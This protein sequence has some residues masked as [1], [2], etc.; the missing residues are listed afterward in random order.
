MLDIEAINRSITYS[1][2]HLIAIVLLLFLIW[3][4]YQRYKK[5]AK[6]GTSD[7]GEKKG[8]LVKLLLQMEVACLISFILLHVSSDL[9]LVIRINL[10]S[11]PAYFNSYV[12]GF[13]SYLNMLFFIIMIIFIYLFALFANQL[14]FFKGK[15]FIMI[16]KLM[17]C[18]LGA[19]I[20]IGMFTGFSW[21]AEVD[22]NSGKYNPA[23]WIEASMG[24][25]LVIIIIPAIIS[26]LKAQKKATVEIERYGIIFI[27][28]FYL[29]I[30]ILL[31]F[32]GIFS[33]TGLYFFSYFS[34]ILMPF[35]I[36]FAYL[37]LIMPEGLRRWLLKRWLKQ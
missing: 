10:H 26:G 1:T 12:S 23:T 16:N 14:F 18:A 20:C 15:W 25:Y 34:W 37:G 17:V 7:G 36:L 3:K 33:L 29:E 30:V 27:N 11:N 9:V 22:S 21:G 6:Q 5:K 13:A 32:Q 8:S 35:G 31:L 24:I 19:L 4:T 2:M 28:L